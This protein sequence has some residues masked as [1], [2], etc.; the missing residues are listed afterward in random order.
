MPNVAFIFPGQ[1]S[2]YIGMGRDLARSRKSS[3]AVFK[4]AGDIL[5]FDLAGLCWEG[6]EDRLNLT[7]YTQPAL[8]AAGVSAWEALREEGISPSMVAGHSLGEYTAIVAAGG[9]EF[10][11]ALRLVRNRGRYMQEAV[12]PGKGA[13]AAILGLTR[14]RVE[15][16]CEEAKSTGVVSPANVNGTLQIVI[17]GEKGAVERAGELARA[18][19]A[20]RVIPLSVSVPSHCSLMAPAAKRLSADLN[21][22]GLEDL[23]FPLVANVHAKAITKAD[24]VRDALARQLE[25]PVLWVDSVMRMTEQGIDTFVEVGPGTVL[26]GL[27]KRIAGSA[28][29]LHA[30][31]PDGLKATVVALKT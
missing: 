20:K 21:A 29:I 9:M 16:V 8:L 11:D 23:R 17:A 26:S 30:G 18:A 6:P 14:L 10:S 19:G 25:S 7:E 1:G 2:Q 28:R 24:E 4:T 13:M 22:A 15:A 31:D 5:G 12:E 27:V 3:E